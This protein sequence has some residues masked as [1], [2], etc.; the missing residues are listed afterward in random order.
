MADPG[1][2][3]LPLW[4]GSRA[5]RDRC[6][7][8]VDEPAR[9]VARAGDARFGGALAAWLRDT[10]LGP[11]P[12]PGTALITLRATQAALFCR[13]VL[14]R[15]D[16]AALGADPAAR[17]RGTVDPRHRP[18]TLYAWAKTAG[19][20]ITVLS[21]HLNR[22]PL[23]FNCWRLRH[24]AVNGVTAPDT[25]AHHHQVPQY[26]RY[27]DYQTAIDTTSGAEE[28]ACAHAIEL[29]EPARV[30]LAAHRAYRL[31]QGA[32]DADPLFVAPR[33]GEQASYAAMRQTAIRTAGRLR[34][35]PPWL[36]PDPCRY[37]ADIGLRHACSDGWLTAACRCTC[38][39]PI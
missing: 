20:A 26:L 29:P 14:L 16:P 33:T 22:P 1:L 3:R 13:G 9:V 11:C 8:V 32:G 31:I 4:T 12:D 7:M 6:C 19:A 23:Y 24:A 5:G 28:I 34:I 10:H 27:P 2:L 38:S 17:L 21:L 35:M 25:G 18:H 36:H 15:W 39:T 37:G 30:I